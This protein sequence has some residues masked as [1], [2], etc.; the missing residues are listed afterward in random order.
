[1]KKFYILLNNFQNDAIQLSSNKSY[2]EIK[3][4]IDQYSTKKLPNDV[5]F[6]VERGKKWTDLLY[7]YEAASIVFFSKRII[8]ILSKRLDMTY[9]CYPIVINDKNAPQYFVLYNKIAYKLVN[10]N[11]ILDDYDEP[12]YFY[13]PEETLKQPRLFTNVGGIWNIVEEEIVIEMKRS[14]VTNIRFR[15]VYS[16]NSA[17]YKEFLRFHAQNK[18]YKP[19]S[20]RNI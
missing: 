14:R 13:I 17:E 4:Y 19:P 2:S 11:Y 16:I 20:G 9:L 12:P 3:P 15:D 1:M 7:Y 5:I 18:P 10:H 6:H 8:D